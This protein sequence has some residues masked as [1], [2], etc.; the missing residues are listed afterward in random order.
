MDVL[1][2]EVQVV[3]PAQLLLQDFGNLGSLLVGHTGNG[4]LAHQYLLCRQI[5]STVRLPAAGGG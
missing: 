4:E 1:E 3:V 5:V 2:G